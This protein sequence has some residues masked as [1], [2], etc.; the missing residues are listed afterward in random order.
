[1]STSRVTLNLRVCFY[2][3]RTSYKLKIEACVKGS[4]KELNL[5]SVAVNYLSAFFSPISSYI[6]KACADT[7]FFF[8]RGYMVGLGIVMER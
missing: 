8:R 2:Q 5:R 1:M 3:E 4:T 7:V 6:P